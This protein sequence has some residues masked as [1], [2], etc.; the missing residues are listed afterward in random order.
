MK[1]IPETQA[2]DRDPANEGVGAAMGMPM[3]PGFLRVWDLV[4]MV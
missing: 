3:R 4:L 1:V 2:M